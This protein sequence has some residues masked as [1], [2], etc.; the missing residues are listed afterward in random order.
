MTTLTAD[1]F[2]RLTI[3]TDSSPAIVNE[4]V[5]DTRNAANGAAGSLAARA[6]AD[7]AQIAR[8]CSAEGWDG[9]GAKAITRATCSRTEAFLND[10]PNWM[11]V[12]DVVPE[13]DGE[14]AIEWYL[15]EDWTFSVSIGAKGP[16]HYAGLF[17]DEDEVHGV[18]AFDGVAI[19]DEILQFI[20]KVL[21]SF[22]ARRVA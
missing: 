8:D 7:L 18:K 14:I 2:W 12:P 10:L 16:L 5:A 6:F 4:A 15:A 21:G 22:S 11:P 19:P 13:A 1:Y 20:R 17:G 9:Y 3:A